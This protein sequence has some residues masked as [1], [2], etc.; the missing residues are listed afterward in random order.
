[1]EE[2]L[3]I[4]FFATPVMMLTVVCTTVLVRGTVA[5]FFALKEKELELRRWE[6][7]Q[8]VKHLQELTELPPWLDTTSA[9]DVAAWQRAL[10]E[11]YRGAALRRV[12][13][14]H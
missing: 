11:T 13:G 5:R 8:R 2:L 4:V 14:T 10:V 12:E 6:A 7:E 9:S 1:M 3:P